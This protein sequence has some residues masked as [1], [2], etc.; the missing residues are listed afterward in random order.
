VSALHKDKPSNHM[1]VDGVPLEKDQKL[2]SEEVA[3]LDR[4]LCHLQGAMMWHEMKLINSC[5]PDELHQQ[6]LAKQHHK[7]LSHVL[8]LDI[9]AVTCHN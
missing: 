1:H 8:K 5:R 7:W 9:P 4:Y 2:S 3:A 6:R